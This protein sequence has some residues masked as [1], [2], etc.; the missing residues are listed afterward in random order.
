[1]IRISTLARPVQ[2][3][4][5]GELV[6]IETSSFPPG[7]R[8]SERHFE[9]AMP[10][11]W[12]S[13]LMA[14]LRGRVAGYAIVYRDHGVFHLSRLA[15]AV[16]LQGTGVG[17]QLV[18]EVRSDAARAGSGVTVEC[19]GSLGVVGFYERAGFSVLAGRSL[20]GYLAR[21]GKLMRLQ[22]FKSRRRVALAAEG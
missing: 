16:A 12:R 4:R 1:M 21:K 5:L 3:Q 14:V 8:W 22:D 7:L 19:D 20:L 18:R 17:M 11:K 2:R 15:V 6:A 9:A 10:M 13:S